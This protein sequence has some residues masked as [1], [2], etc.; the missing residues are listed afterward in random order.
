MKRIL[1]LLF[2][3]HLILFSFAGKI[4]GTVFDEKGAILS[5]ASVS[6]KETTKGSTANN[7]GKYSLY[8]S[9]GTYTLVC[10]HVGYKREEK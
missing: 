4:S 10:Q 6:I 3:V 8:L 5:F 7:E 2:F 1:L 9:P